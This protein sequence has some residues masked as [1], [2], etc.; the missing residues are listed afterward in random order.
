M[1]VT[2]ISVYEVVSFHN[3]YLQCT[4][5]LYEVVSFQNYYLQCTNELYDAVSS[6][7]VIILF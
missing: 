4:N 3:Y 2:S 1:I 5:E 6:F 7:F